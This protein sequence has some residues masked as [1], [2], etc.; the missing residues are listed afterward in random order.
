MI[1]YNIII[2][3]ELAHY[4]IRK[5]KGVEG[6][7]AIKLDMS[8]AYDQVKWKFLE[9]MMLGMGFNINWVKFIMNCMSL[10][11]YSVKVNG[12]LSQGFKSE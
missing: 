1:S 4:L 7:A 3:Y 2:A 6:Y 11:N 10:V 8:K 9:D 12:D 5:I